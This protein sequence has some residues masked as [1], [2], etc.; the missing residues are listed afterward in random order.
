MP[1]VRREVDAHRRDVKPAAGDEVLLDTQHSPPP[2]ESLAVA[3]VPTIDGAVPCLRL[4]GTQHL[5]PL[6]IRAATAWRAFPELNAQRLWPCL[7]GG[8]AGP[9]P[10]LSLVRMAGRTMKCRSC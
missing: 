9:P 4:H 8:D 1:G 6:D 5:P 10:C 3:A 7:L 2:S